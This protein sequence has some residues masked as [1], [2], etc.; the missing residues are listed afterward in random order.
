MRVTLKDLC[1]EFELI[2]YN[3][4]TDELKKLEQFEES[5]GEKKQITS[6]L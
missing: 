4:V 6:I 2:W 5:G 1:M 3:R